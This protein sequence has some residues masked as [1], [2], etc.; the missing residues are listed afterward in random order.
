MPVTNPPSSRDISKVRLSWAR[1]THMQTALSYEAAVLNKHH[2]QALNK[3]RIH[4]TQK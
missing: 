2:Q 1:N 3:Q 4:C